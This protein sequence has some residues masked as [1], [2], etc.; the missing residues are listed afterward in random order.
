[1]KRIIIALFFFNFCGVI[2]GQFNVIL[3]GKTVN[4]DEE[5]NYSDL[6]TLTVSF[7]NAEKLPPNIKGD[8][9][10]DIR[11]IDKEQKLLTRLT[12]SI[13]GFAAVNVFLYP[14]K[15]NE[16]VVLPN[17]TPYEFE[18]TSFPYGQFSDACNRLKINPHA[19][20][21]TV[22]FSLQFFQLNYNSNGVQYYEQPIDVVEKFSFRLKI[23]D[24]NSII[25]C[26]SINAKF[27]LA[28]MVDVGFVNIDSSGKWSKIK[29]LPGSVNNS[30]NDINFIFESTRIH[31][32]NLVYSNSRTSIENL[33]ELKWLCDRTA[34][35]QANLCN[36]N[37]DEKELLKLVDMGLASFFNF[38]NNSIVEKF[39]KKNNKNAESETLWE[40]FRINTTSGFKSV[41]T[42]KTNVCSPRKPLYG[43]YGPADPKE[44]KL[45]GS[46]VVYVIINPTNP[47]SLI[48]FSYIQIEGKFE[49]KLAEQKS[50][51]IEKFISALNFSK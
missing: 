45:N 41:N 7:S 38:S 50:I 4:G 23:A 42:L 1:M 2:H 11:I 51:F 21:V 47:N 36:R 13:N 44:R 30:P 34:Y 25:N 43:G 6:K 31:V 40:P 16:Y 35:T 24:L 39:D 37:L 14:K 20:K 9:N 19:D 18:V 8:L 32:A 17:K 29:N 48:V 46:S 27:K 49:E 3:N 28:N 5:F 26:S 33:N 12:K 15:P 10:F 22:E